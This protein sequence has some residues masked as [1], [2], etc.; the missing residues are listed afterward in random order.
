VLNCWRHRLAT[1]TAPTTRARTRSQPTQ[2]CIVNQIECVS[3][4]YIGTYGS[5]LDL[6][7][8]VT[9]NYDLLYISMGLHLISFDSLLIM[10]FV[11]LGTFRTDSCLTNK[12]MKNAPLAVAVV[13]LLLV[14]L[15]TSKSVAA[16]YAFQ[17]PLPL[18]FSIHK[19]RCLTS[20]VIV[21]LH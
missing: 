6:F 7:H 11:F 17:F 21:S 19:A 2:R 12:T 5:N 10:Q 1:T 3:C 16:R 14:S 4:S 13:A 15:M 8:V 20:S 18:E 9:P